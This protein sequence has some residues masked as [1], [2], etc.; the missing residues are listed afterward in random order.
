MTPAG[1]R[2]IVMAT[3]NPG[4]LRELRAVLADVPVR[5]IGLAEL[6]PI[7]EPVED[8][9]TFAANARAK[10]LYYAKATGLWCLA[11]DSGLMVDALGGAPGVHSARFAADQCPPGAD[12]QTID[13]ANNAKLLALL[14]ET[15]DE[16]RTA[17]FVCHLALSD[18]QRI[19]IETYDTVAGRILREARGQNGFGY[20]PLFYIPELGKTTAELDEDQKNAVSHR[21]K[22]TRHF[23]SLLASVL[24]GHKVAIPIDGR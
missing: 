16:R 12:R 23:A 9:A 15:P 19:L 22:A 17:K 2:T 3:G 1:E 5:V 11:D 8:G 21:G 14:G 13:R 4:K 18:G 7:A 24:A 20:D 10:A 6:P